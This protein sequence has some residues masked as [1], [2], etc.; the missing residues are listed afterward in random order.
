MS[1]D[2]TFQLVGYL[3]WALAFPIM[4]I[5]LGFAVVSYRRWV[6]HQDHHPPPSRP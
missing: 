4:G 3:A 6:N 2:Q 5:G 1:F